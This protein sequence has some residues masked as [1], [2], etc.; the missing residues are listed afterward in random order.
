[1]H[2][3][4]QSA[5][6]LHSQSMLTT[7]RYKSSRDHNIVTSCSIAIDGSMVGGSRRGGGSSSLQVSFPGYSY[8]QWGCSLVDLPLGQRDGSWRKGM[9][10]LLRE[11]DRFVLFEL[12]L[13]LESGSAP[14]STTTDC[15][16]RVIARGGTHTQRRN[17]IPLLLYE[18]QCV[19]IVP[20]V[21]PH[22]IPYD[23]RR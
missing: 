19:L 11:I 14:S 15:S 7:K 23:D 17:A 10:H 2:I 20:V 4:L 12:D 21:L 9:H 22:E 5:L 18:L 3:I 8:R 16:S 13:E 6:A 1:M